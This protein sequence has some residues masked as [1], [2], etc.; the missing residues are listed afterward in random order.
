MQN[1]QTFTPGMPGQPAQASVQTYMSRVPTHSGHL[2]ADSNG[3]TVE[4][5]GF[6]ARGNVDVMPWRSIVSAERIRLTRPVFGMGGSMS[7]MVRGIGGE[8]FAVY[9]VPWAQALILCDLLRLPRP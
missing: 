6:S 7:F 5:R 9:H 3:I 8:R 1:Y 4:R 2:T